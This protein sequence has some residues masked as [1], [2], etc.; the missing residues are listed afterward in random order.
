MFVKIKLILFPH[1]AIHCNKL[2][3]DHDNS[4]HFAYF[5]LLMENC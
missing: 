4:P 2:I 3:K 1:I 5:R